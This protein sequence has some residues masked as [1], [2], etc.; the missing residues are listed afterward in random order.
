VVD[1]EPLVGK[2]VQRVL[3]SQHEVVSESSA[4]SALARFERGESF[5]LVLC[6]LM[7]PQMTG[8]ELHAAVSFA[9]PEMAE[10]FVFLTGG[11]FT[12]AAREFLDRSAM[13]R[14]DKPFEPADLREMVGAELRARRAGRPGP[15]PEFH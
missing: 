4:R 2:A 7:M 8:M 6:D 3:A 11:A 5:D 10:R 12:P 1:D 9:A 15:D 14:I 13:R